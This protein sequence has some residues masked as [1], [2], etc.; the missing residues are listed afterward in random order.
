MYWRYIGDVLEMY[1]RYNVSKRYFRVLLLCH[2]SAPLCPL[3]RI[4]RA[5]ILEHVLQVFL[6]SDVSRADTSEAV[7]IEG[8]ELPSCS[9]ITFLQPL[10]QSLF[11]VTDK[12]HLWHFRSVLYLI[13][14]QRKKNLHERVNYSHTLTKSFLK[15]T[16]LSSLFLTKNS[17]AVFCIYLLQVKVWFYFCFFSC[18]YS[19]IQK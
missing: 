19:F 15:T 12:D 9:P 17:T 10:Y 3:A 13:N 16:C 14:P 11:L 8:I 5:A 18:I 7:G 1:W 2:I 6:I 4:N